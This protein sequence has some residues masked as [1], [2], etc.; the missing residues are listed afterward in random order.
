MTLDTTSKDRANRGYLIAVSSAFIL[1]LTG[2]LIR[3]LTT[4]YQLPALILAFW[5]AVIV[6]ATLGIILALRSP[7]LLKLPRKHL[8]YII[9]YGFVLAVFNSTWTLSVAINGAAA[10]TVMVYCSAA[11][12]ALLAW[13]FLKE[14]LGTGKLVAVVLS[15]AGCVLVSAAYKPE[16]WNTNFLGIATGILAG[17]CYAVYSLMGRSASNRGLLPWTT[18]FY[19]FGFDAVFLLIFNLLPGVS[20]PGA[21]GTAALLIWPGMDWVG[22]V[23]LFVLAA[24]PTLLG[25][26]TYMIS[27]SYLPSSIVNLIAT[28]EPFFTTVIAFF[29]FGEILTGIQFVGGF[30]IIIGV[31]V[32]RLSEM[33]RL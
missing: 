10:A 12:T 31:V 5:R 2:I 3:Y 6:F 15:L 18:L 8:P 13:V 7:N 17:L 4:H 28:L 22:W 21:A 32:T 19:I 26:G 30:L 20:I 25:F 29:V 27:L 16:S 11:F 14:S 24:V 23:V 1:S 9:I 33:R